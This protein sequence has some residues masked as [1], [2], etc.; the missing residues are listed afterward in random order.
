MRGRVNVVQVGE[1]KAVVVGKAN[2]KT[3]GGKSQ[4]KIM[5]HKDTI[6]NHNLAQRDQQDDVH[7]T[8]GVNFQQQLMNIKELEES[9]K[10]K[11]KKRKKR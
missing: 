10:K 11:K 6:K 8:V 7:D 9:K 3:K 5:H 4:N 2:G 1:K